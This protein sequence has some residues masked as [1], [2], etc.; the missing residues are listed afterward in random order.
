MPYKERGRVKKRQSMKQF[1]GQRRG[2]KGQGS[3]ADRERS[4]AEH[5]AQGVGKG[6]PH[7]GTEGP[8]GRGAP[9]GVRSRA[10]RVAAGVRAA[11]AAAACAGSERQGPRCQ[12]VVICGALPVQQ[13][14]WHVGGARTAAASADS[15]AAI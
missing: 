8:W 6:G 3:E 9:A 2:N 7:M 14:P 15:G 12:H 5:R 11:A 13:L 10:A 4:L 1:G